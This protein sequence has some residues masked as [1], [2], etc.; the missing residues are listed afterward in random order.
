MIAKLVGGDCKGSKVGQRCV[1][2]N[3]GPVTTGSGTWTEYLIAKVEDVVAIP[4]AV[5]DES[6]SQ[7]LVNPLAV[8]GMLDSLAAPAVLQSAGGSALGKQLIQVAKFR[9]IKT[10]STVRRCEQVKELRPR[11]LQKG[12]HGR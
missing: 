6:A 1:P 8:L 3:W 7:L 4:E 11:P 5:N 12:R 9:G 10:I 2:L